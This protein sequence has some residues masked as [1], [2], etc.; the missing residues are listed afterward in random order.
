MLMS[1]GVPTNMS[2]LHLHVFCHNTVKSD[3]SAQIA[4]LERNRDLSQ[5]I[6]TVSPPVRT[7]TVAEPDMVQCTWIAMPF[8][9]PSRSWTGLSSR[10]VRHRDSS[11]KN[12]E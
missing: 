4:V 8:T 9:L 12:D 11:G 6:G 7:P 10:M 3:C 5:V 1:N 2:V